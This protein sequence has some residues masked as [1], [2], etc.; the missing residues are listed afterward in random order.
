MSA[1]LATLFT[2]VALLT[3]P[4]FAGSEAASLGTQ[5]AVTE[6]RSAMVG[7]EADLA[8]ARMYLSELQ[9][10]NFAGIYAVAEDGSLRC[11][12]AEANP[13]CA[14]L[15]EADKAQ[16][17]A[18]ARELIANAEGELKDAKNQFA[19]RTSDEIQ[20]ASFTP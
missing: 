18:E 15:T 7:A 9:D 12:E 5:A 6:S 3:A 1:R 13:A 14:P 17:L 16:A 19:G 8:D 11:G 4:A 20:T 10:G 2:A